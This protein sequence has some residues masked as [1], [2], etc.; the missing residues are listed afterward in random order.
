MFQTT[1]QSTYMD[2]NGNFSIA[3]FD[4]RRVEKLTGAK[5]REW[6]RDAI[7]N[8]FHHHPILPFPTKH[9]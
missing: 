3:T 8:D 1:N 6:G 7:H 5:H 9:Q 4:D 2:T